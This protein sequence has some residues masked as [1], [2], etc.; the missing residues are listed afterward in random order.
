MEH[1][2]IEGRRPG[3]RVSWF[4]GFLI[5]STGFRVFASLRVFTLQYCRVALCVCL[6]VLHAAAAAGAPPSPADLVEVRRISPG[7]RT[8]LRYG[9]MQNAFG[10]RL[11]VHPRCLL[12]RAVAERLGRVQRR[13]ALE[14]YGLKIW[15]AYRP[16][17]VQ[18]VMWRI[19]PR[20]GYVG[21]PRHG[22]NHNRGA[23]VDLTLVRAD[24]RPVPMP[25][26]FDDFSPR[27]HLDY[28]GVPPAVR[29]NRARLLQA[30]RAEGFIPYRREWWHY[31]A[32]DYRR[33]PMLDVPL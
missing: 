1:G 33:Y 11:Y 26:A 21:D 10:R 19:H 31:V 9:T 18:R 30:M 3:T 25:S 14:G 32:P 22:S 5:N 2:S 7:I 8:D 16:R 17:S 12:R 15:D 23:A 20:G 24:G 4:P 29:E 6:A 13:L 28:P 27:A